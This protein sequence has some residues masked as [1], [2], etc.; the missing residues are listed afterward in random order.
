MW[1]EW[2]WQYSMKSSN[3]KKISMYFSFYHM[4]VERIS[5]LESVLFLLFHL[6]RCRCRVIKQVNY[7]LC[8]DDDTSERERE[9]DMC[10]KSIL[11]ITQCLRLHTFEKGEI[12]IEDSQLIKCDVMNLFFSASSFHFAFVPIHLAHLHSPFV[13]L[14]PQLNG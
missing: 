9:R 4:Q 6:Q 1:S 8:D 10:I 11:R 14:T 3:Y 12:H 5:L 7:C 2:E 13:F